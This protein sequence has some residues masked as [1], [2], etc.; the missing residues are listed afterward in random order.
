V[1][2]LP[3]CDALLGLQPH[4]FVEVLGF[5]LAKLQPF[6]RTIVDAEHQKVVPNP[7]GAIKIKT[8]RLMNL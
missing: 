3:L 8:F 2:W 7:E 6:V 4:G 1:V 5:R